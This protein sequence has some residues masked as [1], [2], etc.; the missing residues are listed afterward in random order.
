MSKQ[1]E[2]FSKWKS[3]DLPT[4]KVGIV[5]GQIPPYACPDELVFHVLRYVTMRQD[6]ILIFAAYFIF[7][8]ENW[9]NR[10]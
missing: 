4:C 6:I 8:I 3:I 5:T 7:H 10:I 1:M 9:N 2:G